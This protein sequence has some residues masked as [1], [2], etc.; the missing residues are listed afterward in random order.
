V[1]TTT[2]AASVPL[3]AFTAVLDPAK[4]LL[5]PSLPLFSGQRLC[6]P[7]AAA[8]SVAEQKAAGISCG[9]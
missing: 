8:L 3:G 6:G 5:T 2:A 1:L 7:K 4:D 9:A